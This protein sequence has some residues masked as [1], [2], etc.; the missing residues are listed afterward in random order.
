MSM[1]CQGLSWVVDELFADLK[2]RFLFNFGDDL[3]VYSPSIEERRIHVR[4]VLNRLQGAGF[5]LSPE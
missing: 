3:V 1:G 2:E 5:T 4:E